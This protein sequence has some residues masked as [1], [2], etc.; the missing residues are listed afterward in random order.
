VLGLTIA[1]RETILVALEDPP[2]DLAEL[3][4]VLLRELAWLR[5]E[6]IAWLWTPPFRRAA[7]GA[8]WARASL[9]LA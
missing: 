5:E 3:W 2:A 1:E 4:G 6:G 9:L 8:F 7:T